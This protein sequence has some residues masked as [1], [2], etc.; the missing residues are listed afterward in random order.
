MDRKSIRRTTPLTAA[1][2]LAFVLAACSTTPAEE[3]NTAQPTD[4][5]SPTAQDTGDE[6]SDSS[7]QDT[8]ATGGTLS[9]VTRWASG[10][11]E[12][13]AQQRIFDAFT[14]ATGIALEVT[15][16]LETIDDQVETMVAGNKAP[17]LVIVNL[18]DK[19]LG[20]Y[21]ARVT[22]DAQPYL[23][24]WGLAE[25]MKEDALNEWRVGGEPDGALQGLPYSGFSWPVWYNTDLLEKAGVEGIPTTT[26]E[27]IAAAEK[28]RA[29]D[30]DP[31][32]VGGNDWTGQKLFYQIAQSTTD[33]SA[34][35][36]VM[37]NGGYCDTA[38]VMDGIQLF[39]DLRDAGVFVD[40]VA[41]LTADDMYAMYYSE[42]AA[43]MSA[44]SWAYA[45]AV[46]AGTGVEE[47]TTLGGFALPS[48]SVFDK[49]SSLQ[50]FTGV[51]F[52]ITEQ[53][54]APD[55]ID[56]VRQLVQAFYET[57]NVGDFVKTAS[58]LPPV[59]GDFAS[60]ATNPLL[61]E[62]LGLDSEVSYAVMPDVWIGSASDPI[63]A[64]LA[65]AYGSASPDEI[66]S[67][68]DSATQS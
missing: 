49:P 8:E 10:S 12:A 32:V 2:A 55:R 13:E 11:P 67:G 26:D 68:L 6:T 37:Q 5:A 48:G 31:V 4:T 61:A 20:W 44:G 56:L 59:T 58:I 34:M 64:V 36:D 24:E 23:T 60:Y 28:L 65:G 46:D 62:A 41:G 45:G 3:D 29:A 16:G 38:S 15:E 54:A 33:A 9:V 19:T 51:G 40:N 35:K 18:F 52:M 42:Q 22:V 57:Q 27:L 43:I 47:R 63:I 1:L 25:T 39:T 50:G 17:D 53:G 66:C 7:G 30:I 21:E 14:A